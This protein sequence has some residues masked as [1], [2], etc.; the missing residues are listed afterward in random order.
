M[1]DK[2]N[3][4]LNKCLGID[5]Q[6]NVL[7]GG[8]IQ[9]LNLNQDKINYLKKQC[10]DALNNGTTAYDMWRS[11][12]IQYLEIE[13]TEDYEP[14]NKFCEDLCNIEH[15]MNLLEDAKKLELTH[16][17]YTGGINP[18]TR[19]FCVHNN[20][21]IFNLNEIKDWALQPFAK[22]IP[23]YSPILD[24]GGIGCHHHP[25]FI[26]EDLAEMLKEQY[27]KAADEREAK[28]NSKNK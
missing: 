11:I 10:G 25:S 4:I 5:N 2:I 12:D 19:D 9:R 3:F 7:K 20:G 1:T 28:H 27:D 6:N 26:T 8:L 15:R 24:F 13:E 14:I 16:F 17:I 18:N 23:N 22:D 21:R